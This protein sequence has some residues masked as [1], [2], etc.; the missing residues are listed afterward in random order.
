MISSWG[1]YPV[2]DAELI[3]PVHAEQ[4]VTMLKAGQFHG[5]A[6]GMGRSY[7]D[8]A[9][10]AQLIS[11]KH[12]N[13]FQDFNA[14]TGVLRCG[15]GVT[16]AEIL[17]TFVPKGW[18]LPVTP[19]TKFV[20]VGGAIGS[21]VHGK[22]HHLHG[23]F[24]DHIERLSLLVASGEIIELS[25]ASH[26]ELFKAT[27]GG[28]GL[29]GVIL[30]ASIR[31]MPIKSAYM[32]QRT[33]KAGNLREAMDILDEH[34]NATYSVAW[35]DCVSQGASMGRSLVSLGEHLAYGELDLKAKGK[36]AVPVD[37]PGLLLNP[38]TVQAFNILYYHR[39][40]QKDSQQRVHYDPHFYPLDGIHDWNRL[41]G[42]NGFLQYQLVLP[43][44]AGYDGMKKVLEKISASRKGSFLAVLKL[45]GA[46]NGNYLSFPIEGYSLALDFKVEPDI[47]PLLDTLDD[48][49]H[50]LGGRV[51][52][53]KD[54]RLS[55]QGFKRSYP[56][57]Q[58]FM[59]V[60]QEYGADQVFNS[61]QSRRLGL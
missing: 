38:L 46:H 27:C 21:D 4:L 58:Q 31:L 52:L 47:F 35:I 13:Y 33:I 25:L 48:I 3:S 15:A 19:G 53:T 18:F 22:N 61:L 16:L 36:L 50:D 26:P 34:S 42:K 39:V 49:V 57:W 51:Y 29:T 24:S 40:L 5:V 41:Y 17:E 28:M 56:Q 23:C 9:L 6:R 43:K 20:S 7:G 54:A 30:D 14:D 8:S 45:S 60:R 37:M 11:L 55:E 32:S 59:R 1:K 10:A 2:I 12:L 44:S